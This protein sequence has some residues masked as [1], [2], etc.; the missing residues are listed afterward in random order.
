MSLVSAV[1]STATEKSTLEVTQDIVA[2]ASNAMST[3]L[4]QYNKA[5]R[6]SCIA[7]VEDKILM[8]PQDRQSALMQTALSLY[9]AEYLTAITR[10]VATVN[11]VHVASILG[12]F[13]SERDPVY[14]FATAG[15]NSIEESG[16]SLETFGLE[17][18]D[19][20][21]VDLD[22]F[23]NLAVG[24]VVTFELGV[25]DKAV[26]V[27]ANARVYPQIIKSADLIP[28]LSYLNKD[29]TM[30]G[31]F[32]RY[33]AGELA[34]L[35]YLTA[36]DIVRE[37]RK[38]MVNDKTGILDRVDRRDRKGWISTVA[39][40]GK[41]SRNNASGA[42]LITKSL[43]SQL[44]VAMR[45]KLSSQAT[46]DKFFEHTGSMILMVINPELE[47]FDLYF[48]SIAEK[49][50]YSFDDIKAAAKNGNAIDINDVMRAYS[51][52]NMPSL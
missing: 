5:T 22:K 27:T 51:K 44:E 33:M 16:S 20:S 50:T 9:T 18:S 14:S 19:V 10:A 6:L 35:D 24:K 21:T 49:A 17:R 25:G 40:K 46:R 32:H 42:I 13:A 23:G 7:L 8:L 36:L 34:L 2:V 39:S 41:G 26:P 15:L 37:K 52:S 43:A 31:R 38:A 11:N 48:H 30:R 45:G 3:S 29:N 47:V 4:S 28:I 12:Q 1:A